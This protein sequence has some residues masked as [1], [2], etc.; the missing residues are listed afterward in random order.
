MICTE[1]RGWTDWRET[2]QSNHSGSGPGA[3]HDVQV[4]RQVE[5][6]SH[7]QQLLCFTLMEKLR[8]TIVWHQHECADAY[9]TG[10]AD[11]T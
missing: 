1:G 9:L 11:V 4:I 8:D 2:Y 10:V 5:L 6:K 7:T 3:R